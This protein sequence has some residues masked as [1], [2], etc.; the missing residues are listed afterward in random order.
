MILVNT[1]SAVV[2]LTNFEKQIR[3][4][5]EF[6]FT[7]NS[8]HFFLSFWS[9]GTKIKLK[10]RVVSVCCPSAK[11]Y[12]FC[13]KTKSCGNSVFIPTVYINVNAEHKLHLFVGIN[14]LRIEMIWEYTITLYNVKRLSEFADM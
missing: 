2:T 1:P 4:N 12:N 10:P 3:N 5:I 14:R 8:T 9:A 7:K 6:F 13:R 11:K